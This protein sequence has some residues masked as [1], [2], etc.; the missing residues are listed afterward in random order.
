MPSK[1]KKTKAKGG[2]KKDENMASIPPSQ[3]PKSSR[4]VQSSEPGSAKHTTE[5]HKHSEAYFDYGYE[6]ESLKRDLK[7]AKAYPSTLNAWLDTFLDAEDGRALDADQ[8]EWEEAHKTDATANAENLYDDDSDEPTDE[9]DREDKEE[10][11]IWALRRLLVDDKEVC[12]A[13]AEEPATFQKLIDREHRAILTVYGKPAKRTITVDDLEILYSKYEDFF[14]DPGHRIGGCEQCKD[15]SD[16]KYASHCTIKKSRLDDQQ[17]QELWH[18]PSEELN[19]G[20]E[21]SFKKYKQ[22]FNGFGKQKEKESIIAENKER[23]TQGKKPIPLNE[24]RLERITSRKA[25]L[26]KKKK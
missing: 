21:R 14:A 1:K 26:K 8:K 24:S 23:E 11:R 13:Y 4:A 6:P 17:P 12:R 5:A 15:K 20:I 7:Y 2:A 22:V 3:Q 16:G 9:D 18:F 25:M 19:P 10:E